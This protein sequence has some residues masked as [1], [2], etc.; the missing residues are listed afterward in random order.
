[1]SAQI[2]N[3]K[4]I[5][6]SVRQEMSKEVQQLREKN[7]VPGLAVILVGDNQASQ[8]YV[9][10]KQK[11]CED[12]GMHSVLIKK[13]AELSQE[14]L[15]QSI[16]ELNQDDSIHGILVQLPLPGHIQEKAIIE[17]ISPEKDVDGFHPINIGRMMTGQDAFLPCTPYGV[18]VMLEYIDYDLEG[19]HVVIVG[20]SNIVGKPAGQ[21]FLNAN[22][23][24]TYCHSKT[25]DL[26]YYTKQAD[27]V[28]AAVGKRDTIT[29]EHIKE[30]AVVIDVGM[31]RNEEGKLC[32]D[33]A[34]DEV[35]N[36]ASFITPVPKGV[37]P[38]TITML[39]KNT[40]KSAQKALEQNKQALKS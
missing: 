24:V 22:A 40:V 36:K 32:G 1:M 10:H 30:G 35:K 9:R 6:E 21:M 25:K 16:D 3:G 38:M 4:E 33:V 26:A 27:V 13:P 34:F 31:N 19:K 11:A 2:I 17:A 23:T 20:R 8:T 5:A 37:G 15:I 7:I 14:E 29:S 28:V 39:M 12:L 18:M